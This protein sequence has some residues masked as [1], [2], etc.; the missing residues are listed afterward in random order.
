MPRNMAGNVGPPRPLPR[1]SPQASPLKNTR[2][3]SVPRLI[4]DAEATRGPIVS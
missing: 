2:Y 4:V 1:E 3:P